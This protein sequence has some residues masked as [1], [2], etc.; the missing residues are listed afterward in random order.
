[1]GF[2]VGDRGGDW[3]FVSVWLGLLF[4]L[5]PGLAVFAVEGGGFVT[6]VAIRLEFDSLRLCTTSTGRRLL[7]LPLTLQKLQRLIIQFRNIDRLL[8]LHLHILLLR[9]VVSCCR[10]KIVKVFCCFNPIGNISVYEGGLYSGGGLL[11]VV[12]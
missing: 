2:L 9:I 4:E 8:L 3:V 6:S 11:L 5:H 7:L 12:G 10:A 1:M